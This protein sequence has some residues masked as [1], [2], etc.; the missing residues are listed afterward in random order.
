MIIKV[1]KTYDIKPKESKPKQKVNSKTQEPMKISLLKAYQIINLSDK[2]F[3]EKMRDGKSYEPS[4][5]IQFF[6]YDPK[7]N[8]DQ[9]YDR[10]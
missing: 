6:H 7:Y 4:E 8:L 3:E 9:D 5:V 2:F 10:I 1:Y